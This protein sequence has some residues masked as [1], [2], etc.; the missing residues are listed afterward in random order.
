MAEFSQ[1][2]IK[3]RFRAEMLAIFTPHLEALGNIKVDSDGYRSFNDK[4]DTIYYCSNDE[5]YIGNIHSEEIMMHYAKEIMLINREGYN[6]ILRSPD[7]ANNPFLKELLKRDICN[8]LIIYK[9]EQN[10]IHMF[11]FIFSTSNN[12]AINCFINK[13]ELFENIATLCKGKVDKLCKKNEYLKLKESIFPTNFAESIFDKIK[14]QSEVSTKN[15]FTGRQKQCISLLEKGATNKDIAQRLDICPKTVE[16]HL[17]NLKTKLE[18]NS[19]FGITAK[20]I[21]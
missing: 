7:K 3:H 19:R 18:C 16:Y 17:G 1:E 5:Y 8:S 2:E 15:I 11:C 9:M 12:M 4:G 14:L 10:I 13:R 6:F 20:L 21:N